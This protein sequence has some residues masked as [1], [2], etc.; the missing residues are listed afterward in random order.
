MPTRIARAGLPVALAIALAVTGL[1]AGASPRAR[2]R[3]TRLPAGGAL[4]TRAHRAINR[5][6]RHVNNLRYHG[7]PVMRT[8]TTYAIF[9]LPVGYAMNPGYQAA[10][11]QYFNDVAADSGTAHNVYAVEKQYYDTI[12]HIR[13]KQKFGG[14]SVSIDPFPPNGCPT[15]GGLDVCLTDQ[16][17]QDEITDV[18]ANQG[19]SADTSHAYFLFLPMDVGTC[20]DGFGTACAFTDFCAYHSVVSVGG[21]PLI[22]ANEPYA[23]AKPACTLRFPGP[24][25]SEADSTINTASHEHREMINDPLLDAWFDRLGNEGSDKCAWKFG[26]RL[27]GTMPGSSYNQ[28]ING[29]EYLLQKEWSNAI[30]G[31]ALS[32]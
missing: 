25:G 3:P 17:I 1:S 26:T 14:A 12:G 28:V 21:N 9:W 19:W 18:V 29:N 15:Y 24:R 23:Q 30:K 4:A 11:V 2:H 8:N 16:Q 27:P 6:P 31:C 22:Y 20:T 10:I 5:R 7:G 32:A 13:Y